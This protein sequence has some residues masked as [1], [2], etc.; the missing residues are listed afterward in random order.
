MF[1]IKMSKESW[2][3]FAL[4]CIVLCSGILIFV[5]GIFP[6][7]RTDPSARHILVLF[8]LFST[9]I[10]KN[11]F[12]VGRISKATQTLIFILAT[13]FC[14][15][16]LLPLYELVS[17]NVEPF[18][19]VYDLRNYFLTK[20]NL[21]I[22]YLTPQYYLV[23][24]EDIVSPKDR[25]TKVI[26]F[27]VNIS[28]EDL[29]K[30]CANKKTLGIF[31]R[32]RPSI[33]PQYFPP[34]EKFYSYLRKAFLHVRDDQLNMALFAK[35]HSPSPTDIECKMKKVERKFKSP[36]LFINEMIFRF[37]KKIPFIITYSYY[38]DIYLLSSPSTNS[39]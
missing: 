25:E 11:F 24:P 13:I 23:Y 6:R 9:V 15:R 34:G 14:M 12:E 17:E 4:A 3:K 1:S 35:M 10:V 26:P 29:K 22:Y 27:W 5:T 38:F 32:F 30:R 8:P 21:C 2:E 19:L 31:W 28:I 7:I 36:P 39:P 16:Q 33:D 20:R 37:L 18:H